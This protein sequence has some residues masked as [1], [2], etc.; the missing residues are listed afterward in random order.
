MKSNNSHKSVNS[1]RR[2]ST[3]SALVDVTDNRALT[4]PVSDSQADSTSESG[5]DNSEF[6]GGK[7]M[8]SLLKALNHE[9]ESGL[10]FRTHIEVTKN[11]VCVSGS[12]VTQNVSDEATL[13]DFKLDTL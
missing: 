10:F 13:G 4:E 11:K 12:S 2:T 9:H 6:T 8:D 5:S 3:D 1:G 7:R